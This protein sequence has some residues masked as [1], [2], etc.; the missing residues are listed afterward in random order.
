M[1]VQLKVCMNADEV[2]QAKSRNEHYAKERKANETRSKTKKV[3]VPDDVEVPE[4]I[5]EKHSRLWDAKD[6]SEAYVNEHYPEMISVIHLGRPM[7]IV[8]TPEVW[9]QLEERFK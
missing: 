3:V 4:Q 7:M 8:N 9:E 1:K 2:N 5:I 6:I